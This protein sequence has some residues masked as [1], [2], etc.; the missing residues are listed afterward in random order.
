MWCRRRAA[1]HGEGIAA[2]KHQESL[3]DVARETGARF[4]PV[5]KEAIDV[6]GNLAAQYC[7]PLTNFT[8]ANEAYG[9]LMLDQIYRAVHEAATKSVSAPAR[10]D[11][12]VS[13]KVE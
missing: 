4:L 3:A 5:P 2:S 1:S 9:R 6:N 13:L 11:A 10:S 7:G 12:A 8:H